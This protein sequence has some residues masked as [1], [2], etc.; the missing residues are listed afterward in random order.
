MSPFWAGF[1]MGVAS[2]Y[3]VS[4]LLLLFLLSA[5]PADDLVAE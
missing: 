3:V 4:L 5:I 1:W 2:V